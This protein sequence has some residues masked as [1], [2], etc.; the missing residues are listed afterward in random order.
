MNELL[1]Q[2]RNLAALNLSP[3]LVRELIEHDKWKIQE[4]HRH[5]REMKAMGGMVTSPLSSSP[6]S[7]NSDTSNGQCGPTQEGLIS[8]TKVS[9]GALT[10]AREIQSDSGL[11]LQLLSFLITTSWC[12][13]RLSRWPQA[14]D[15]RTT[16]TLQRD[17][18]RIVE[19]YDKKVILDCVNLVSQSINSWDSRIIEQQLASIKKDRDNEL[20]SSIV[21]SPLFTI[22]SSSYPHIPLDSLERCYNQHRGNFV[23]AGIYLLRREFKANQPEELDSVDGWSQR[24]PQY[25][26]TYLQKWQKDLKEIE[27]STLAAQREWKESTF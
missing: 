14:P 15:S 9:A 13:Q 1:E 7:F 16:V 10:K 2:L 18:E 23:A 24:W 27:K 11:P 25:L 4:I 6:D 21:S 20:K 8:K 26:P 3:E 5:E 19:K 17:F 22:F 12:G